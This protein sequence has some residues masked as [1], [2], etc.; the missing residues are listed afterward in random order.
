VARRRDRPPGD[1]ARGAF[2][3]L[4]TLTVA[5]LAVEV[6]SFD[7]RFGSAVVRDRVSVLRRAGAARGPRGGADRPAVAALVVAR[8]GRPARLRLPRSG[9]ATYEKLNVDTPA[10]ALNSE[11]LRHL[12]TADRARVVLVIATLLL[13]ALFFE[14]S[15]FLRR[16]HS[17]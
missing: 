16:S 11:L 3:A 7:L 17:A 1:A 5:V 10:S 9:A 8:A 6:T 4:G 2:A 13:T 15:L 12:H 14:A